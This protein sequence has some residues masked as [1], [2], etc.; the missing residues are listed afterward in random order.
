MFSLYRRPPAKEVSME[1]RIG[2]SAQLQELV[3]KEAQGGKPR[4]RIIKLEESMAPGQGANANPTHGCAT[5][6]CCIRCI[7]CRAQ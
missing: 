5:H 1:P 3:P 4:F 2:Q 6:H 7:R